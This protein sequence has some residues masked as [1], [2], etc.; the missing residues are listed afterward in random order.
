MAV[1]EIFPNLHGVA[2]M[3]LPAGQ[4]RPPDFILGLEFANI[5]AYQNRLS[6]CSKQQAHLYMRSGIPYRGEEI[7]A[8]LR[9]YSHILLTRKRAAEQGGLYMRSDPTEVGVSEQRWMCYSHTSLTWRRMAEQGLIQAIRYILPR[10][11]SLNSVECV[12]RTLC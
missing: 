7:W 4:R 11:A 3:I 2:D 12:N 9:C 1:N 10:W 6:D 5:L 8:A